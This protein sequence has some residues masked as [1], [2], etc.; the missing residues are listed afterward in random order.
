MRIH[1]A[2]PQTKARLLD[3][4]EGLMLEKGFVATTVEE[5]CEA[6]RLTKGSFFHYFESKD[7]LGRE[8]LE[9]FCASGRRM[10]EACC[11]ADPD[12]LKRV[13]AYL[14]AMIARSREPAGRKGCLLGVFAQELCDT[15]PRI[16]AAC[17]Q[18]FREWAKTIGKALAQAKARHAPRAAMNPKGLAEHIIAVMEG[19]MIL[20]KARGDTRVMA[21]NLRHVKAY[22]RSLFGR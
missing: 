20:G 8:L 2:P 13:Y 7:A 21:R 17:E 14:D 19:S 6:A 4:A 9:R 15:H 3:A 16:R 5:I 12:P 22:V 10:H 11:G 18:G 1:A